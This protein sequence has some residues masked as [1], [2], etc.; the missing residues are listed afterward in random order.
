[1]GPLMVVVFSDRFKINMCS[2]L[3]LH[4]TNVS[5]T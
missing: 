5:A 2:D 3:L 4:V 1:M